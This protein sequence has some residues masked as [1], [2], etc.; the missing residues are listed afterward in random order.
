MEISHS[1]TEVLTLLQYNCNVYIVAR[2]AL[3]LLV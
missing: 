3:I 1:T 2:T